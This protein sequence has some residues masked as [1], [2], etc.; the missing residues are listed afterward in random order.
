MCLSRA[1]LTLKQNFY[2]NLSYI[3]DLEAFMLDLLTD[4]PCEPKQPR[5]VYVATRK[6]RGI[7]RLPI[8]LIDVICGYFLAHS[9]IKLH[10]ASKAL[11]AKVMLN[12]TF[13]RESLCSGMLHPYIWD[14]DMKRMDCF[15]RTSSICIPA[16]STLNWKSVT[17]LLVIS[18][19]PVY[20]CETIPNSMPLGLW[21]RCR[22]WRVIEEAMKHGHLQPNV[23]L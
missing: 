22:I 7:E 9:T 11:D 20:C 18:C 6:P 12:N 15:R 21:N 14:L 23:R 4:S 8:E 1:E 5:R 2:A 3:P 17:K 13:W 16:F 10:R 19:L